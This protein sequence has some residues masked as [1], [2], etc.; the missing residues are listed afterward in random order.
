MAKKCIKG[1]VLTLLIALSWVGTLHLLKLSFHNVQDSA[2]V[3]VQRDGTD[4]ADSSEDGDDEFF[5]AS[6]STVEPV[7]VSTSS[8]FACPCV[9]HDIYRFVHRNSSKQDQPRQKPVQWRE[10]WQCLVQQ[11]H[12]HRKQG[13][14]QER[15]RA[16]RLNLKWSPS[17]ATSCLT[18]HSSPHGTVQ[19]GTCCFFPSFALPSC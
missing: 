8:T 13:Q 10:R 17:L 19:C 6:E 1:V 9:S 16:S 2:S 7:P 15:E 11:Q 12:Q 5:N 14:E 4:A 3:L 18:R